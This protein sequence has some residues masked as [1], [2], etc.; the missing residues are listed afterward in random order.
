MM[1]SRPSCTLPTSAAQNKSITTLEDWERRPSASAANGVH[2]ACYCMN[3]MVMG[4]KA[5]LD[6]NPH[7]VWIS[8]N[9][10]Q[11]YLP[12]AALTCGSSALSS[13]QQTRA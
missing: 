6:K 2:P 12:A 7:H 5:L 4:A 3:G 10:E 11:L 13:E 9:P 8:N 1:E